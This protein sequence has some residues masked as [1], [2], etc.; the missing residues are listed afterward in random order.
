MKLS[1]LFL[2]SLL[3]SQSSYAMTYEFDDGDRAICDA[4]ICV[5]FVTTAPLLCNKPFGKVTYYTTNLN[6]SCIYHTRT[7]TLEL[8]I[9]SIKDKY[10]K[11]AK[12]LKTRNIMTDQH[13]LKAM[14]CK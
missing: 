12:Q 8:K 3:L 7:K 1:K 9:T 13:L 10:C 2:V 6:D 5:P 4:D 14:N 11:I